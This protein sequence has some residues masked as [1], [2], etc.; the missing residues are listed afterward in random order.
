[1][2]RQKWWLSQK[3]S[4]IYIPNQGEAAT[5]DLRLKQTIINLNIPEFKLNIIENDS[6]IYSFPVRVG[7]N[8]I[9]YLAM[10][11]REV[12]LRTHAGNGKI[13]RI[14]R[15]PV[16]INPSN[17]HRYEVTRRDDEQVTRLP[18]IPWLEPE[19]NGLRYGQLIHPTTNPNT[20]GKPYSNGCVGMR[21]G[22]IW[23]FIIMLRLI[24]KWYSDMI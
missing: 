21:E 1:M 22:D 24:P 6:I 14:N 16:Y 9:K 19:I 18:R 23:R 3:N 15:D 17:N 4:Q 5:I 2:I 11:D 13:V 20:L 8:E 7:R 12:D 10:A